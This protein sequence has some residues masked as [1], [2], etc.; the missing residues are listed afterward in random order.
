[1]MPAQAGS[2]AAPP[3]AHPQLQEQTK[4][5]ISI[6]YKDAPPSVQRQMEIKAGFLPATPG[7]HEMQVG[8]AMPKPPAQPK[9]A[10]KAA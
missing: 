7:E 3:A 4:E 10:Q 1:M 5:S 6:N 8:N 9:P 2:P